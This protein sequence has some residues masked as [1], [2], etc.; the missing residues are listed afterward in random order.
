MFLEVA[1]G[2][3]DTVFAITSDKAVRDEIKM[4]K[5]GVVLLKKFD[6][7]RKEYDGKMDEKDLKS[8]L[9]YSIVLYTKNIYSIL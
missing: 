7:G 4:S 2:L 9:S 3:D 5:D 8:E 6:E 1:A